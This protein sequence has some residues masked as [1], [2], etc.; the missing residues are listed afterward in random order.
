MRRSFLGFLVCVIAA[1]TAAAQERPVAFLNARIIPIIGQ[2]IE[3]GVIIV[4]NGKITA[5][6]DARAARLSSDVTIVD[7]AGKVIMP[8][9]VDTH[10]HIGGPAGALTF[11]TVPLAV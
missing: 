5:V 8:G 7:L 9:L 10:S 2:P 6:G 1:W 4:Q 3:Q 11:C